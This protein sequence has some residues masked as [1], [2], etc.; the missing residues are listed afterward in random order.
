[1]KKVNRL[2]GKSRQVFR[3]WDELVK[4]QGNKTLEEIECLISKNG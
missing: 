3:Y 2:S 4:K 1:M